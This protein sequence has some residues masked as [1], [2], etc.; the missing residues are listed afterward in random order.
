MLKKSF[1]TLAGLTA[2]CLSENSVAFAQPANETGE[3]G[4][5][6]VIFVTGLR[7]QSPDHVTQSVSLISKAEIGIRNAPFLADTLRSV[8]G[9][10][11]SRSGSL[12]GL[13]QVRMRGGEANHTLVLID[14]IELSDPVTG[15]TDFGV[16]GTLPA[17]RI[18]VVRGE[19]SGLY[20][21]DAIGGVINVV[22]GAS[23][24]LQAF[25]EVGSRQAYR[26]RLSGGTRADWGSVQG[27]VSA[28]STEGVDTSGTTGEEDGTQQY[29]GLATGRFWFTDTVALSGLVRY[30]DSKIETDADTDFDGRLNDTAHETDA[31]Q[32]TVGATLTAAQGQVDHLLRANLN[33]VEREN[34]LAGAPTN[35]A[36]G[37]RTK[38]SYSPS[39]ELSPA[40]A[41]KVRVTGLLE[42]ENEDYEARDVEF[43]GLTNNDA[44]FDSVGI[45]VDSTAQIG[46]VDLSAAVRFDDN[47]NSFDDAVTG[48]VGIAYNTGEAGRFRASVGT[49]VKNPTFTELFGFFPGSFVGNPNL[50][51]ERSNS[52]ELGWT[53]GHEE[54]GFSATYFQATL[55]DE[56]FTAFN[57][58]FTAT[59]K[60]RSGKS[61][62]KGLELGGHWM[63]TQALSLFGQATFTASEAD[64]GTDEI[65]VPTTTASIGLDYD[66]PVAP[67]ARVGLAVDYVGEQDD[68]DFG[69][70]PAQRVTLDDYVLVSGT[71]SYPLADKV[72]GTLRVENAFDQKAQDVFGYNAPGAAIYVGI[73]IVE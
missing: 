66:V 31:T 49:G 26:A 65:R 37:T 40:F 53:V 3:E 54:A 58:D 11:V 34:T 33:R 46:R 61:K 35:K 36:I 60:N 25:G 42:Y 23:Q 55:K 10:A 39:I 21:S 30:S 72:V 28:V 41:D 9:L 51:P 5:Q 2:I 29:S 27:G 57:P 69:A 20:G 15:E 22:P 13:T 16:L 44:S 43:G 18:E 63:P 50:T 71:A 52:W 56:I 38:I 62:R 32:W 17:A 68:F 47:N 67:E 7:P 4:N 6:D 59:A 24:G 70:F 45:A 12:G 14:G 73:R 8:P 48:R 19:Q 1:L 64:D